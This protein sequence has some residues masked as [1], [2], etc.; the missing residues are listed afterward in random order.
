MRFKSKII[1]KMI[2]RRCDNL[3]NFSSHIYV[4]ITMKKIFLFIIILS[5]IILYWC[6]EKLPQVS[7]DFENFHW[8]FDSE[9]YYNQSTS[10]L[11]WQWYQLLQNDIITIYKQQNSSWFTN[12]II[13]AKRNSDKT[14]NDFIAENLKLITNDWFKTESSKKNKF[15]CK[16]TNIEIYTTNSKVKTNLDTIYLS[17]SFFKQN[18]FIYIISFST[19]DEIERNNFSDH[20]KHITCE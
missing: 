4:Y 12:S 5:C 3:I 15:I 20:I 11:E 8:Y 13:I 18:N 10:R 14:V 17:Q 16:D 7:Y 19:L 6:S 2:Y 1:H 9:N